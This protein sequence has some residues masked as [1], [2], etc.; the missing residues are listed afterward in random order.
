VH[1]HGRPPRALHQL[2]EA[3]VVFEDAIVLGEA[4]PAEGTAGLTA[5]VP[6]MPSAPAASSLKDDLPLECSHVFGCKL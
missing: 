3:D 5:A 4:A 1:G 6:G 2:E